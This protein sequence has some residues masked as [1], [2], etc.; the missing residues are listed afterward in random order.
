MRG[1]QDEEGDGIG[2]ILARQIR[3]A[4][5]N[6]SR[7]AHQVAGDVEDGFFVGQDSGLGVPLRNRAAGSYRGGPAIRCCCTCAPRSGTTSSTGTPRGMSVGGLETRCSLI[8]GHFQKVLPHL[9]VF[10][11]HHASA[12]TV[13]ANQILNSQ[14]DVL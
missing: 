4:E 10:S 1:L 6:V 12:L 9:L 11:S 5:L 13:A 2:G 7:V 3:A 14:N 8:C